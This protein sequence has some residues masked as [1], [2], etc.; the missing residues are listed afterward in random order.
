MSG[1]IEW[2][3]VVEVDGQVVMYVRNETGKERVNV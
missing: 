3:Y 1:D 2:G